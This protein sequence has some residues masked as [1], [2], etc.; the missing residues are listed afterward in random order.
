MSKTSFQ[1]QQPKNFYCIIKK[2]SVEFNSLNRNSRKKIENADDFQGKYRSRQD[3]RNIYN[4]N[5]QLEPRDSR[6]SS[7]IDYLSVAEEP[8]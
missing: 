1:M 7:F 3:R 4:A 8:F 2:K 5:G 6:F